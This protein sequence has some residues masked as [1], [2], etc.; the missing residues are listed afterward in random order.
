[1]P[2]T[3]IIYGLVFML[4]DQK[5]IIDDHC[6]GTCKKIIVGGI[7]CEGMGS[8]MVCRTPAKECPQFD[9]EIDEPIGEV[10]GDPVIIRKLKP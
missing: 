2:D 4:P 3:K 1:M 7:N 10:G 8:L 6:F 5:K 9:K